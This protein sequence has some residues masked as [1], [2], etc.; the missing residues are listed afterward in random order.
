[1]DENKRCKVIIIIIIPSNLLKRLCY[2]ERWFDVI[3]QIKGNS[4]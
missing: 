1:M 2:R 4:N 3:K